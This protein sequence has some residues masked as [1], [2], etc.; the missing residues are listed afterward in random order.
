M[1]SLSRKCLFYYNELF[2]FRSLEGCESS[3]LEVLVTL[4]GDQYDSV[5]S[6]SQQALQDFQAAGRH[7]ALQ[8]VLM[9]NLYKLATQLPRL[10]NCGDDE[11]T[12]TTLN[13]FYGYL[14]LLGI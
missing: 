12:L 9:E 3:L 6:L 13:L 5:S 7:R 14:S 10:V 4:V 1:C 11:H 8:D 2:E